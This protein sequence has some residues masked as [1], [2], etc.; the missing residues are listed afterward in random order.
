MYRGPEKRSN[1]DNAFRG[2][3]IQEKTSYIHL[4]FRGILSPEMRADKFFVYLLENESSNC[5]IARRR[6]NAYGSADSLKGI[7]DY[8]CEQLGILRGGAVD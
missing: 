7:V 1:Y 2:L 4:F 3:L 5:R 8:T 6:W